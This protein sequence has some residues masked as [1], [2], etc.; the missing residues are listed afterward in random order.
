MGNV[1]SNNHELNE[2]IYLK[3][4]IEDWAINNY[5]EGS[6]YIDYSPDKQLYYSK[7]LLKKRACCIGPENGKIPINLLNIDT[8][9]KSY[10]SYSLIPQLL[11]EYNININVF[12]NEINEKIAKNNAYSVSYDK[13]FYK[14][15]CSLIEGN[16]NLSEYIFTSADS[17][18]H[19]SSTSKC[20]NL[21]DKLCGDVYDSRKK[22]YNDAMKSS[23]G[24]NFNDTNGYLD[25]NC[26]NSIFKSLDVDVYDNENGLSNLSKLEDTNLY[27]YSADKKCINYPDK[28]FKQNKYEPINLCINVADIKRNDIKGTININQNCN[29]G[30]F[31]QSENKQS[32]N[33]PKIPDVDFDKPRPVPKPKPSEAIVVPD[34]LEKQTELLAKEHGKMMKKL[35]SPIAI[36]NYVSIVIFLILSIVILVYSVKLKNF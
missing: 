33:L 14:D 13:D 15:V 3:K 27:I 12:K 5:D 10:Q 36:V 18:Y 2:N 29:N 16:E 4:I 34:N 1:I 30:V 31:D 11:E 25:C 20:K 24:P 22:I 8:D 28:A 19:Y 17:S 23:Y 9:V 6:N 35:Y 7:D 32:D 21:F 26:N